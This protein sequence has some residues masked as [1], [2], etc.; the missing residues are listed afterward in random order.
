M[1]QFSQSNP[2]LQQFLSNQKQPYNFGN[3]G[4]YSSTSRPL[5]FQTTGNSPIKLQ[6]GQTSSTPSTGTQLPGF[7]SEQTSSTPVSTQE[8]FQQLERMFKYSCVLWHPDLQRERILQLT[9]LLQSGTLNEQQTVAAKV[10][11]Q[12]LVIQNAVL[13]QKS[14]AGSHCTRSTHVIT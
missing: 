11:L 14:T 10:R 9:Q 2:A 8:K 4:T 12:Q 13:Q 3:S 7:S 6:P 1:F 5:G